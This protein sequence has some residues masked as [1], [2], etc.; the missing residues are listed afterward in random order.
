MDRLKPIKRKPSVRWLK[1]SDMPRVFEIEKLSF[2]F[3]WTEE[4]FLACLRQRNCIS[5]VY[6]SA[7][8]LVQG[9]MIYELHKDMLR[10]LVLAVAPEV[11]R[12]GV[13]SAMIHGL[14]DKLG[15]QR[16]HTIEAEVRET[17][18]PAQK[19][20]AQAGFRAVKTLRL[21]Y[22]ETKEDA[23]LFRYSLPVD[24]IS[25]V[26]DGRNRISEYIE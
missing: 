9:F 12:T 24:Q 25:L 14:I 23:Y 15:Q 2:E 20:L 17:N 4:E 22:E 10:I 6:E 11:R 1:R 18:L 16:R 26:R 13:G 5:V 7:H 19:F 8:G 21:H 3:T